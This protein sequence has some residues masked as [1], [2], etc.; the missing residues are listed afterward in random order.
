MSQRAG[1]CYMPLVPCVGAVVELAHRSGHSG[2]V[3]FGQPTS[4]RCRKKYASGTYITGPQIEA[5]H[6]ALFFFFL[7]LAQ[8]RRGGTG[9]GSV[10]LGQR[11]LGLLGMPLLGPA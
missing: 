11:A 9:D 4:S 1:V 8:W 3:R 2:R 10:R 5:L 7:V 6:V